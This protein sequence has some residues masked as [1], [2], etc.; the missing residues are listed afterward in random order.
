VSE[1]LID[2][3]RR[4]LD[5]DEEAARGAGGSTPSGRWA[6][7]AYGCVI[8]AKQRLVV[9]GE[10]TPT[11]E[12]VEHIARHDPA[13]VLREVEAFR[14]IVDEHAPMAD[15]YCQRCSQ[16]EEQPQPDGWFVRSPCT[17]IKLLAAIFSGR[18]AFR[19]EWRQ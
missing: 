2:W 5:E 11:R 10:G 13:R 8:D 3:L 1:D 7:E 4:Q 18:P 16:D 9:Y 19:E 17:T 14:K 15:G 6:R 12:E